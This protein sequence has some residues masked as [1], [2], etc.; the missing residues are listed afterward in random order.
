M[1]KR[2]IKTHLLTEVCKKL[3]VTFSHPERWKSMEA[4]ELMS[5][6]EVTVIGR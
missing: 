2:K 5:E 4:N 1:S 3:R 6:I